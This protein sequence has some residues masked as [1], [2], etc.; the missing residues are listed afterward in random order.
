MTRLLP[1]LAT[2]AALAAC[3]DPNV[4][5][6]KAVPVMEVSVSAPGPAT[7]PEPRE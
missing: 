2:M 7:L 1:M 5:Y 3:G 6:V 4:R